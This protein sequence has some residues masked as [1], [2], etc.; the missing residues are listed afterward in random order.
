M[1]SLVPWQKDERREKPTDEYLKLY[2]LAVE[3]ADRTSQQSAALLTLPFTANTALFAVLS[4][5]SAERI[6]W[7][8]ALGGILI[9]LS[10]LI[11]LY[12]YRE[13]SKAKFRVIIEM[14]QR[15]VDA[16]IFSAECDTLREDRSNRRW[17]HSQTY[18]WLLR[19][20]TVEKFVPLCFAALYVAAFVTVQF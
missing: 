14:E 6:F 7:L 11:L 13:L 18:L 10:W 3:M 20:S 8:I 17:W 4:T 16:R 1:R 5:R 12:S 9:S 19:V 15:L 2:K